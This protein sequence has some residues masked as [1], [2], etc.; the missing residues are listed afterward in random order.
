MVGQY[1]TTSPTADFLHGRRD[2]H[3]FRTDTSISDLPACCKQR[4]PT[5]AH[6]VPS[7]T[8]AMGYG[9][10]SDTRHRLVPHQTLLAHTGLSAATADA[11]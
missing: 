11:L 5:T 10:A 8:C 3:C 9:P 2:G 4:T 1:P 6:V 7:E